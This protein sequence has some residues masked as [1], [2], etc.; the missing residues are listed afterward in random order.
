MH[1]CTILPYEITIH[2]YDIA[3]RLIQGIPVRFGISVALF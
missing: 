1:E 2:P 3:I